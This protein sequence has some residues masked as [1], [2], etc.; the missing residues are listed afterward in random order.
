MRL[1]LY[2]T[3]FALSIVPL[4]AQADYYVWQEPES[5]LTMS[6]PDTWKKRNNRHVDDVLSIVGPSSNNGDPTCDVKISNDK[7]YVIYPPEYGEAV[8]RDAVSLPFWKSYMANYDD[9]DLHNVF[10][11]GGLG[12]WHASYALA[13]YDKHNGSALEQRRAIMFASLYFDTLY[14]VECS[15]LNHD[16]ERWVAD[17]QSIIKSI[18]FKKSYHELPTGD[19]AN[20]LKQADQ[21]F[22]SQTGPAGTTKY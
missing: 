1:F 22:W 10:D 5:G 15:S 20:F 11:G 21:Y 16:Y 6:Y 13:S 7:R 8:Q 18:D 9:Y 14:I 12:R 3:L 2:L 4:S 19:Y 17:F